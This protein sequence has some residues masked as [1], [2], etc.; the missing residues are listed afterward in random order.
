MLS[1]ECKSNANVANFNDTENLFN[2]LKMYLLGIIL[3]QSKGILKVHNLLYIYYHDGK[4][5]TLKDEN[6]IMKS[7]NAFTSHTHSKFLLQACQCKL[8]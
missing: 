6:K 1:H 7:I 2:V 8:Q 5:R 3:R 4:I